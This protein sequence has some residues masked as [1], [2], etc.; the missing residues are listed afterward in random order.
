MLRTTLIPVFL[1][2]A[3]PALAAGPA[4]PTDQVKAPTPAP[5]RTAPVEDNHDFLVRSCNEA[6][7]GASTGE[8]GVYHCI[9]P[10]GR[11]IW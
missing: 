8:D 6:G 10:Q 5:K 7:G 1:A 3:A 2:L 4:A 11:T 9:D